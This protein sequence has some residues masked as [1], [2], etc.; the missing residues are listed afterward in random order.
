M[1]LRVHYPT[2]ADEV[3]MIRSRL[4]KLTIAPVAEPQTIVRIR[5]L[6][7][8]VHVDDKIHHYIVAIG[9]ATRNSHPG[10]LP[11]VKQMLQYGISPRAYH[12]LLAMARAT[13]FMGGR[14][15]VSPADVKYIAP[16]VLHHRVV[17]TIRAEVE[18]V[19]SDEVVAEVL[20]R[21]PIP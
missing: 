1:M 18:G 11:I 2:A 21:T 14:D 3:Q 16:D 5:Q 7:S 9:Q 20:R 13:A 12:H 15:F 4:E 17:R 6:A 19:S 8:Q 10:A